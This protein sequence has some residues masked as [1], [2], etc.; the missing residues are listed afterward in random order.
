MSLLDK[1]CKYSVETPPMKDIGN[2]IFETENAIEQVKI[3]KQ[4]LDI[5]QLKIYRS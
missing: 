1:G 5:L 2:L 3:S 4:Q